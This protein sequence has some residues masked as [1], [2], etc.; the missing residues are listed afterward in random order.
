[1]VITTKRRE[2]VKKY[3]E[4]AKKERKKNSKVLAISKGLL[5][6]AVVGLSACGSADFGHITARDHA[7][8]TLAGSPQGIGEIMKGLN[9]LVVT[10]KAKP[11]VKDAYFLNQDSETNVRGLI[12]MPDL[13]TGKTQEVQ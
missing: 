5:A 12:A 11:N 1:M 8:L 3:Q 7:R 2:V 6:I 9:G 4:I 13:E 10:G